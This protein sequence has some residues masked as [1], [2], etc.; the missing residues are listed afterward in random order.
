MEEPELQISGK[1]F[2]VPGT[3]ENS[4]THYNEPLNLG[5]RNSVTNL[6]L[7]KIADSQIRSE[8]SGAPCRCVLRPE[9]P[10]IE[11][12]FAGMLDRGC[13]AEA[14]AGKRRGMCKR[15]MRGRGEHRWR[16]KRR[17]TGYESEKER[18]REE[19]RGEQ[20]S[21]AATGRQQHRKRPPDE[22]KDEYMAIVQTD[23]DNTREHITALLQN[24]SCTKIRK[25]RNCTLNI[26]N[27]V[28]NLH[29]LTCKMRKLD[30]FHTKRLVSS[31]LASV[32][33]TCPEKPWSIKIKF[34]DSE[35]DSY[36]NA[37]QSLLRASGLT[38]LAQVKNPG[39]HWNM[40]AFELFSETPT[41]LIPEVY[42]DQSTI[43]S[44]RSS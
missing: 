26:T 30:L 32:R 4:C 19:E 35:T 17:G 36:S 39:S 10:G 40:V 14:S 9:L 44:A 25:P 3:D 11:R 34:D 6:N 29:S 15:R 2:S 13:E 28:G 23:L 21:T 5:N 1:N 16:R 7:I 18:K 8:R 38:R 31:L 33:C 22:I 27:V 20:Q 43:V 41:L 42:F 12:P 37:N 24:S